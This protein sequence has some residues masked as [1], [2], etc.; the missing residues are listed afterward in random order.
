MSRKGFLR[1]NDILRED[2]SSSAGWKE[3]LLFSEMNN[4]DIGRLTSGRFII[5]DSARTHPVFLLRKIERDSFTFCPCSSQEYNSQNS[6]Y[7]R[8]GAMTPPSRI[9]IDKNSY[10]L[11]SLSFNL[12]GS[13]REIDRLPVRGLVAAEDIVGNL[14][15]RG[16][17]YE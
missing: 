10:I 8:K 6:S 4:F 13:S 11:H 9:P 5:R 3:N 12:N 15:K 7:I 16:A 1:I 2:Y 17:G 14:H